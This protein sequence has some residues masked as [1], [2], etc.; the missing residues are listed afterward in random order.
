MVYDD[1]YVIDSLSEDEDDAPLS[2]KRSKKKKSRYEAEDSWEDEEV[3]LALWVFQ[4]IGINVTI[5]ISL[6]GV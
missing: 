4:L 2:S 5:S 1:D 3:L 6:L